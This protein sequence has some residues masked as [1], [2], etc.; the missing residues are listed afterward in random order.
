M[1]HLISYKWLKIIKSE[2]SNVWISTLILNVGE[3]IN[4]FEVLIY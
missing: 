4:C 1:N 3:G 2:E